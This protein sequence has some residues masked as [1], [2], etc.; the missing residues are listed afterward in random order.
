MQWSETKESMSV[1]NGTNVKIEFATV[2]YRGLKLK[3]IVSRDNDGECP[4]AAI[5]F[6]VSSDSDEMLLSI[7]DMSSQMIEA[8]LGIDDP[9]FSRPYHTQ[10]IFSHGFIWEVPAS[11][12]RLSDAIAKAD[13]VADLVLKETA[14]V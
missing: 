8:R 6:K 4:V 10:G 9:T 1:I 12:A 13:A 11:E 14:H 7:K 3:A 2:D 5:G